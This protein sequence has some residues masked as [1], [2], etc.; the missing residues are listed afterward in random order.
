[1]CNRQNTGSPVMKWNKLNVNK[2]VKGHQI[3]TMNGVRKKIID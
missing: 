2:K 1:M 3:A